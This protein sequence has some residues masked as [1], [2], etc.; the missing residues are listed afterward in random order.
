MNLL[1]FCDGTW[2]TPQQLDDGKPAPTNVVKLRNAVAEN[3]GQ[4]VYYHPGVGTD[5]G[6][7]DRYIGGGIGDGLDKNIISAYYW[8]ATNYRPGDKIWLFG[9]SRGAY[10]VRSLGGMISRCGLLNAGGAGTGDDKVWE[11]INA[12]FS[13]YRQPAASAPAV[14]ASVG[15][16]FYEVATGNPT[17]ESVPVYF[18][19]VWETVGS[20]GIPDD[21]ALA[22]LLD[23]PQKYAFHD[24]SLSP[25]VKNAR[26]ALALDEQ[27]QSQPSLLHGGYRRL[28]A[29]TPAHP[30]TFDV[31]SRERWNETGVWLEA[32]VEYRFSASGKWMDSSIPCDA[33]GTD[34][35]K[36]YPGEAAQILASVADKLEMLWKGATKNQDVDFWLSRRVGTAPWF[37]LIGVVANGAGTAPAVPQQLHQIFV[38]GSGCRFTPARS[39]YLYAYANDAWQMYDNN[40][41]SVAL[42]V[43]R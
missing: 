40:R 36:F 6:V 31:F 43:S 14:I 12:L 30:V 37:A 7:V 9:F 8:L 3:S 25:I 11:D 20:L 23:D 29:L 22:N 21:L 34:D 2:N 42:T 35:G 16:P 41:G 4:R 39:G 17:K 10:T 26:H 5:G 19:G 15:R 24:T 13:L 28:R 1:V 33:D 32:G 38:I 27:R 18:I